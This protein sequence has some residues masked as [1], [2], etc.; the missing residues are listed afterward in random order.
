M[1]P[2]AA[3][4]AGGLTRG[5]SHMAVKGKQPAD[6][7]AMPATAPP[8]QIPVPGLPGTFVSVEAEV[9]ANRRCSHRTADGLVCGAPVANGYNWCSKCR[10]GEYRA[11]SPTGRPGSALAV[12][13]A[14]LAVLCVLAAGILFIRALAAAAA[15]PPEPGATSWALLGLGGVFWSMVCW[16][17]RRLLITAAAVDAWLDRNGAGMRDE[18]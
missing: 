6:P 15:I 4:A 7:W 12:A 8:R 14:I 13:W 16:T 2:E 5:G 18:E 10:E 9:Q 17:A 3:A 11:A 1:D